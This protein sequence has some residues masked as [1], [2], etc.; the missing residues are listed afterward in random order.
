[1]V[2]F[3]FPSIDDDGGDVVDSGN[4]TYD[5]TKLDDATTTQDVHTPITI[6]DEVVIKE[7]KTDE[8]YNS[9]VEQQPSHI[10]FTPSTDHNTTHNT[11]IHRL[12][13]T[14][15]FLTSGLVGD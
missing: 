5:K 7:S 2:I 3:A 15:L 12:S 10:L 4:I 8:T 11:K 9:L 13:P 6:E 14:H 1:M